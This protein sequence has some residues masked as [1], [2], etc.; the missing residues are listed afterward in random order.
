MFENIF[1]FDVAH[2]KFKII[3]IK[4]KYIHFF[5]LFFS[6]ASNAQ[7][8][9][10]T[11]K[12]DSLYLNY[13]A[14]STDG[15]LFASAASDKTVK[16]WNIST[17]LSND[18]LFAHTASVTCVKYSI[19]GNYIAS[20]GW[21]K[22]VNI[23]NAHSGKLIDTY[24]E[25]TDRVNAVCF[26]TDSKYLASCSDDKT[27]IIIEIETGKKIKT[28]TGHT[29]AV[30]SIS[31]SPN[32]K[33]LAS[34]S[35][36]KSI[37]IWDASTGI[38]QTSFNNFLGAVND[39]SFSPDSKLIAGASE[40]HTV[41]IWDFSTKKLN[42]SFIDTDAI[43]S[44]CFG[45]NNNWIAYGGKN[46]NIVIS[47]ITTFEQISLLKGHAKGIK[48]LNFNSKGT[49]LI[50]A[51]EDGTAKIWDLYYI[52]YEK[53]IK[54]KLSKLAYLIKP[55]D[56]FETTEN[57]NLRL[58]KFVTLKANL[59]NECVKEEENSKQELVKQSY[60]FV[61]L[62]IE[63]VSSYNADVQQYNITISNNT[64]ILKI[65]LEE[66]KTFKTSWQTANVIGI[67]RYNPS[68]EINELMNLKVI[69]PISNIEFLIG[70]QI[71]PE[72]NPYL[73]YFL[74]NN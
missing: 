57:Y 64:Y 50:S 55:K 35:W 68:T 4:K 17:G 24:I 26:S 72:D 36:D 10:K 58:E 46:S 29:D 60:Q 13:T 8:C 51:S 30:S 67:Q 2:F 19:D 54:E 53:C 3:M 14:F 42:N 9:L 33:Y 22:T 15:K 49:L 47:S 38:L 52:K 56:E 5:F 44:V 32:G 70:E 31:Y 69:H 73:K 12:I 45:P 62:I 1:T 40:D 11:I 41:K 20:C 59:K 63:K 23:W 7:I 34:G 48:S 37:N 71:K 25:H 61:N 27:I 16:I 21:D 65:P 43:N 6:I 39:V 18:T 74:E 66:A 28:I